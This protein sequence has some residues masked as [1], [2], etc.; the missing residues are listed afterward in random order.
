L[1]V[2]GV[3]QPFG[4][5]GGGVGDDVAQ[6]RQ[7][8]QQGGVSSWSPVGKIPAGQAARRG[9]QAAAIRRKIIRLDSAETALI[10]VSIYL[11]IY[12][13]VLDSNK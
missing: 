8:V 2:E 13:G 3:Q 11:S 1:D 9:K 4:Q 12:E 6:V 10:T 7:L 5:G